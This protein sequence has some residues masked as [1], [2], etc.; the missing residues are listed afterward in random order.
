MWQ[1]QPNLDTPDWIIPIIQ[2]YAPQISGKYVAQLLLHRGIQTPQQLLGFLNYNCYQPS[3]P[4]EFGIEMERAIERLI[5]ARNQ[6]KI[7]TIWGTLMP[8]E[9]PQLPYYGMV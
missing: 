1:I 6:Q 3:S 7:I 9:L 2:E 8:M 5:L 4:F